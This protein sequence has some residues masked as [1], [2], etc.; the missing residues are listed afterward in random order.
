M[1]KAIAEGKDQDEGKLSVAQA[2]CLH[3]HFVFLYPYRPLI[4]S[5]SLVRHPQ[6]F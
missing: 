1:N 5:A 6:V 2:S 4:L 3:N